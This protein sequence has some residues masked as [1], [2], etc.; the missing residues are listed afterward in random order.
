M[1]P[2]TKQIKG[3]I[4]VIHQVTRYFFYGRHDLTRENRTAKRNPPVNPRKTSGY[5][6]TAQTFFNVFSTQIFQSCACGRCFES[7]GNSREPDRK[8]PRTKNDPE[9]PLSLFV[10]KCHVTAPCSHLSERTTQN[11]IGSDQP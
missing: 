2:Y 4:P 1:R 11:C 10:A 5:T 9:D 7:H 6:I 3:E 8:D